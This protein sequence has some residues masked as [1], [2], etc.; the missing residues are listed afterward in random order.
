MRNFWMIAL[1]AMALMA[2]GG[3]KPAPQAE[4]ELTAEQEQAVADSLANNL[5]AERQELEAD[6]KEGLDEIDALLE[7]I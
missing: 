2:C 3:N 1:L 5:E 7:E 6:V 4:G